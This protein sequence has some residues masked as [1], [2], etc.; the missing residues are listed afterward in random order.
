MRG[1]VLALFLASQAAA[2]G[3]VPDPAPPIPPAEPGLD[4][5]EPEGEAEVVQ[6]ARVA[7]ADADE[8][9]SLA[10]RLAIVQARVLDEQL[11]LTGR[12]MDVSAADALQASQ[13]AFLAHREA[14]CAAEALLGVATDEGELAL[15]ACLT[16]ITQRRV[17]DLARFG[18]VD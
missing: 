2:Q 7:F 12:A 16:R 1:T 5:L 17:E 10:Y 18:A 8:E 11:A 14:A 4:C 9:R 13:E 6:C 15:L 3:V